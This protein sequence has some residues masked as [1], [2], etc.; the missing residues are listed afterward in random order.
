MVPLQNFASGVLAAIVQRQPHSPHR[1]A[2]A[3]QLAVGPALARSSSVE[4]EHG[5]LTVH[6]RDL[7]W[8]REIERAA[9][10]ILRRMQHVLGP[11]AVTQIRIAEVTDAS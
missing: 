1:T 5:I 2:F 8:G 3:W 4:L 10:T 7:R 6:T 9:G 11:A